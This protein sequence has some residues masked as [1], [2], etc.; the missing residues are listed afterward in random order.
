MK[1]FLSL[2]LCVVLVLCAFCSCDSFKK[3][4]PT[5]EHTHDYVPEVKDAT[6]TEDGVKTFKCACGD[7]YEQKISAKGHSFVDGKCACGATDGTATKPEDNTPTPTTVTVFFKNNDSW[8]NVSIYVW[9]TEGEGTESAVT[10][11]FTEAWPGTAMTKVDGTEDWYSYTVDLPRADGVKLIFNNGLAEGALQTADLSLDVTK[12]YWSNNVPYETKELAESA[13]A[14]A[15]SDWYV[16]GS[17]N[18]WGTSDRFVLG[19]NG[20]STITV[21]LQAGVQFKL[22]DANWTSEISYSNAVFAA[23]PN[24]DWGTDNYNIKVVNAG[25]YTFTI[26]A[27]GNLTITKA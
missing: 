16:R 21:E 7:K 10:T 25:T 1:R 2:I 17:H 18:N 12:L 19:A 8:E 20:I 23:D 14:V 26:D 24:F 5:P 27:E 11:T 6:C 15:Y 22:A 3:P 4:E 13:E 9:Y